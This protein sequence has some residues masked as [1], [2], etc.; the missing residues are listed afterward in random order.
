MSAFFIYI[1]YNDFQLKQSGDFMSKIKIIS[2]LLVNNDIDT[3]I[4]KEVKGIKTNNKLIFKEDSINVVVKFDYSK[5]QI[6]R[7]DVDYQIIMDFGLEESQCL[8]TLTNMGKMYLPLVT[9]ELKV[10]NQEIRV[11]YKIYENTY[12]Y[13]INYEVL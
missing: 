13:V 6:K 8:Y 4:T 5:L 10:V 2:T 7:E 11:K 9:E 3:K 1:C 12:R